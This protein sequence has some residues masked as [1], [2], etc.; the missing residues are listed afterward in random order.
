M[1][2]FL[3]KNLLAVL[4]VYLSVFTILGSS[5]LNN[6]VPFPRFAQQIFSAMLYMPF[7]LMVLGKIFCDL[8]RFRVSG[9]NVL[10]YTLFIYYFALTVYRVNSP[11]SPAMESTLYAVVLFGVLALYSLITE[12]RLGPI[13]ETL[14]RNILIIACYFIA[15]KVIFTFLEGRLFS[16]L[17]IN[18]LYSTSLLVILLPFLADTMKNGESKKAKLSCVLMTLAVALVF[19]CSSRAIVTLSLIVLVTLFLLHIKTLAMVKRLLAA[20]SAALVLVAVAATLNVG[21][22][23]YSLVREFSLLSSVIPIGK[24]DASM[25]EG[26]DPWDMIGAQNQ[27]G[28][29]DAMRAQLMKQGLDEVWKNPIF[30]TGDLYYTY[31]LG[32]KTM[33]QTAHNF[34]IESLVCFGIV[35]TLMIIALLLN[36]LRQ[37]GFFRRKTF[38]S[39]R[40]WVYILVISLYYLALG[41]VQPSVYN[42]LLC[43]MFFIGLAYYGERLLPVRDRAP[44][45][46]V[47]L[48]GK[49]KGLLNVGEE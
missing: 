16:H 49:R 34:I 32:Y 36:I 25:I 38:R 10:Y 43:P 11:A 27:I 6:L 7:R 41:M 8:K 30:G 13:R 33:E 17:P 1:W 39:W 45:P 18:N 35:G 21:I 28:R 48:L 42:T 3:K 15:L 29:S 9:F 5:A 19:V 23:R 37:F 22:V 4:F 40:I 46:T 26:E 47:C 24:T 31:D 2:Q 20:V 12:G 14:Q 44:K